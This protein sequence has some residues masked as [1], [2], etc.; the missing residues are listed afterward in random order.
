MA[1]ISRTCCGR[2]AHSVF[3]AYAAVAG[4]MRP[5]AIPTEPASP[6]CTSAAETIIQVDFADQTE[7]MDTARRIDGVSAKP[8]LCTS[9]MAATRCTMY[10]SATGT[11]VMTLIHPGGHEYPE[12]TS[13]EIV[14]FFERFKLERAK[15]AAR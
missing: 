10:A 7:A 6:C 14:K 15:S 8:D 12:G 11:P 1:G 3:A 4:R 13:E 9:V 2:S 5:G